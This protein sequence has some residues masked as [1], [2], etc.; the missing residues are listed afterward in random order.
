MM[1]S[2]TYAQDSV[3]TVSDLDQYQNLKN[4]FVYNLVNALYQRTN[5][6]SQ[7]QKSILY[8]IFVMRY[9]LI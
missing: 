2:L 3:Y 6:W 9:W 1:L 7:L 4:P 5:Q 8:K